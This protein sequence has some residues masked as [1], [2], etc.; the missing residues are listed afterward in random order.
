MAQLPHPAYED[1][2]PPARALFDALI[3]KRGRLDGMYRT[4]FNHPAL[5][6]KVAALGA[7]LR[8][9]GSALPPVARELAILACARDMGAAY[10]WVKHLGPARQAG[11]PEEIIEAL[12]AGREPP[13]LD[14]TQIAV[15]KGARCALARRSIPAPVQTA[16]EAAYGIPGV[17]ELVVL[18]GFYAMIAGVIFAFDVPLPEGEEPPFGHQ[19]PQP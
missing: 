19:P 3:A 17:V 2:S 11:L 4:L 8:F 10:E 15:L 12:R 1:L 13:G 16:L 14:A 9:G 7:Y 18:C 5:L 6:E